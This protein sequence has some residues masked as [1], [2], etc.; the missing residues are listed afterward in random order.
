ML[1]RIHLKNDIKQIMRDPI[2]SIFLFIPL[3]I[4][5]LFKLL[6][7]FLVPFIESRFAFDF[8]PYH[9]YL[10]AFVLLMN[11]GMLG[12]VTGFMMLDERDGHVFELM[13]VTPLGRTGYLMNRL[14]LTSSLSVVYC[15]VAYYVLNLIELPFYT[16]IFLCV[17][18]A[19]YVVIIG[20]LLFSV[21]EDKVKGLTLAKAINVL[22]LFAFT[23]LLP[24]RWLTI[25]SWFFPPY[26][27]T[28]IIKTP[29]S[30]FVY[31]VVT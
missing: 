20:L 19:M 14:L 30:F 16:M 27:I 22:A 8:L 24:I 4:I 21:A 6:V 28:L 18:S 1:Q 17:L 12:L 23:D 2:M 26:W 10:L 15:L 13:S 11:G 29:Y 31:A 7:V 3:L 25:L 9:P 5:V